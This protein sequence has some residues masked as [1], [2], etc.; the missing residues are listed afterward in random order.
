MQ[1]KK[2]RWKNIN[3]LVALQELYF[4]K[5]IKLKSFQY[6]MSYYGFI[7]TDGVTNYNFIQHRYSLNGTMKYKIVH[8]LKT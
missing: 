2:C 4:P 6:E 3:L 8:N 5:G 1:E 7:I